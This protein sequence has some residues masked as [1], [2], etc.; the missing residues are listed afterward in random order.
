M[1]LEIKIM[2][3]QCFE[4]RVLTLFPEMFPGS[5]AYSLAG[6]AI[7]KKIWKLKT[8]N[9]RDYAEDKHGTVD[10]EPYG[11]GPGMIMRPDILG[12]AFDRNNPGNEWE[13]IVLTPRG[14][15]LT[16]KKVKDIASKPG[17]IIVCG[18][19]EGLDE[20]F[21]TS[22]S[23]DEICIG[24]YVLSGGEPAAVILI[25]AIVRLLCGTMGS[26][27][28][29][30]EESFENDLLEHPQYTRPYEWEG[31]KPP[32]VLLSGNHSEIEKWRKNISLEDTKKRR[33]ELLISEKK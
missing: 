13:K 33:P 28:S 26:E 25:D 31:M 14:Q 8:V 12:K 16:Q 1:F 15:P 10:D 27:R 22:R 5:L 11:G 20:R 24:D 3:N 4:A 2:N 30:L 7:K 29:L 17:V 18:R 6:K 19:Y 21:I 9:I 23:L 32:E